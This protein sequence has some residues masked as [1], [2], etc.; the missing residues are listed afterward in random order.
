MSSGCN[1]AVQGSWFLFTNGA[2]AVGE[3]YNVLVIN[4]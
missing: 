2:F 3:T 4:P 1:G